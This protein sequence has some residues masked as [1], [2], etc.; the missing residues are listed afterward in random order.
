V[1]GV[2]SP[3][4]GGATFGTVV[5]ARASPG[6]AQSAT[7][8]TRSADRNQAAPLRLRPPAVKETAAAQ[9]NRKIPTK[10][11]TLLPQT[12]LFVTLQTGSPRRAHRGLSRAMRYSAAPAAPVHP[13]EGVYTTEPKICSSTIKRGDAARNCRVMAVRL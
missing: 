8:A 2:E 13:P 12:I 1:S 4:S 3:V 6:R 7:A 9:A 11:I 5:C 10:T